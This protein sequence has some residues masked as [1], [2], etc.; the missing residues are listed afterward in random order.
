MIR[1]LDKSI[2][3]KI[4]AG[5]VI[6]RPVSIVKELVEN[7]LDAGA[8]SVVVEIK[9][10]GKS[11]IRVTDDGCGIPAD[12]VETAFLR[13]ATSKIETA[14]DLNAIETLGFRGEALA[15]ICAVTRCELVTKCPEAKTGTRL[16]LHGGEMVAKEATGCPDGT[17]ILV[18]DLF[19]NTP[20]RL[21]FMKS[22]GAESG[23][24]IDFLSQM[25]LAYKD[26]K[27]RLINNG[28]VLFAT[29]GDG[30]RLNSII[31]IYKDVDAKN[32]APLAYQEGSM[33]L[34]GYISTPAFSKTTR[35]SQIF[36]VNGRVV[37]SKVMEKGV[38]LGYQERLFEGR[39]PVV[40]LF[41]S[42]DPAALDVNIHPNKREVRFD[43]ENEIAAFI[44]RGIVS[45]LATESAVVDAGNLFNGKEERA[46]SGTR[47]YERVFSALRENTEPETK[48]PTSAQDK[49]IFKY[50]Q[51]TET[52]KVKEEQVDIK[53]ILSSIKNPADASPKTSTHTSQPATAEIPLRHDTS[54]QQAAPF[55]R[56]I[57][58]ENMAQAS[59]A[60]PPA[61]TQTTS[62][63]GNTDMHTDCSPHLSVEQPS[64]RPF[65]FS[66]L[67]T[68][69]VIFNTYITAVDEKNFYL[70]D[71]HAAHERIFYE[72]LV[73]EYEQSEKS[74]QMLML[75]LLIQVSL[76]AREDRFDWFD[77]LNKMGFTME[78]FG[79]G[80]YRVSEIPMFMELT[81]AEDFIRHFI[82]NIKDSTDLSNRVV[83]DKL[84]TMS[85]KAAVKAHDALKPE[86]INAL[87]HNLAKCRNPFSCPHGRP[88]FIKLTEYEI[89]KMFKRV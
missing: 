79:D 19:Y 80:T 69:G 89:E 31:R 23:L 32:M 17:T 40:Y 14:D 74:K 24:I 82:D 67:R 86:E 20:A 51:E 71:Q 26:V 60:A 11:Y 62:E 15:S 45:A 72:K 75:P 34:E 56:E 50:K 27:F 46:L 70:L 66:A 57:L 48:T 13:H 58:A 43:H 4:A 21:K 52:P 33:A 42:T 37:N 55:Q 77:A 85:C 87:L 35:G 29:I 16:V 88:T 8:S 1:I 39:Y 2:A 83:I 84:I 7:A 9:H 54:A 28:K 49:N 38:T 76:A 12:Q 41:L 5:E 61:A 78:E 6:E 59:A 25:A 36:F 30:N 22:D 73:G 68:T 53:Q 65:D 47:V 81:E 44:S 10:G 63:N 3:D 18:T 64:L